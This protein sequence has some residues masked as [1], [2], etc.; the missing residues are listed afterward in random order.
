MTP[1]NAIAEKTMKPAVPTVTAGG[2]KRLDGT[3]KVHTI[4]FNQTESPA[5]VAPFFNWKCRLQTQTGSLHLRA[6]SILP[7][8]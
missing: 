8:P 1:Q 4:Q 3:G 7:A 6:N 5:M 2:Q